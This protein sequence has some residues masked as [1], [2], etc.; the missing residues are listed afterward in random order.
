MVAQL[1]LEVQPKADR[2]GS[3]PQSCHG[4]RAAER[5]GMERILCHLPTHCFQ[6]LGSP[7][8]LPASRA[9]QTF[10][11]TSHHTPAPRQAIQLSLGTQLPQCPSLPTPRQ[12]KTKPSPSPH[13]AVLL[14]LFLTFS[15]SLS[16]LNVAWVGEKEAGPPGAGAVASLLAGWLAGSWSQGEKGGVLCLQTGE[17]PPDR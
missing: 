16:F 10:S 3:E 13:G 17:R 6:L 1:G 8:F 11:A 2:Q 12:V 14:W 7:L 4:G 9:S 15:F 5:E